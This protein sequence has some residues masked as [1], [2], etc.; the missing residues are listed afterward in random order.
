MGLSLTDSFN[1]KQAFQIFW[2]WNK[3]FNDQGD[4]ASFSPET[5]VIKKQFSP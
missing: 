2:V 1:L 5:W 4:K 3:Q